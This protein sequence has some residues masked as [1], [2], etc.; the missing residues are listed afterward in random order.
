MYHLLF[1][2][3]TFA[4]FTEIAINQM[5]LFYTPFHCRKLSTDSE[6]VISVD[7]SEIIKETCSY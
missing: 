2:Y 1:A 3:I 6:N 4:A 7:P 5:G